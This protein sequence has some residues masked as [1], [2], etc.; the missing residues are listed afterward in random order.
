MAAAAV[1]VAVVVVV[2]DTGWE[3]CLGCAVVA[4]D[5]HRVPWC[6]MPIAWLLG[7]E[8]LVLGP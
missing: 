5:R 8:R 7:E 1:V 4:L 6:R 2:V 3:Q